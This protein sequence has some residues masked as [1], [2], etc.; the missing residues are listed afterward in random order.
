MRMHVLLAKEEETGKRAGSILE[1]TF[2]TFKHKAQEFYTAFTK[3]YKAFDA[4]D[5]D[6]VPPSSKEMVDTVPDKLKYTFKML[7]PD[8]DVLLQKE[9][10]NQIA[11]ADIIVDGVTLFTKLPVSF[12]LT[13]E[14]R[15]KKIRELLKEA[16]TL[17]N[18][19]KWIPAPNIG[20]NVY[21]SPQTTQYRSRKEPYAFV[22]KEA[23]DKFPAQVIE[24]EKTF[25]VGEY[26]ETLW[27]S[28][29]TSSTKHKWLEAIDKLIEATKIAIRTANEAEVVDRQIGTAI[30]DFILK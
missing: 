4:D 14:N 29:V 3:T 15:L 22:L 20:E 23:T 11:Q 16:P 10:T 28:R 6:L 30:L 19:V 24:K 26:T 18:G 9:A 13:L 2:A 8:I 17:P 12:L 5:K 1:E 25:T 21:V 7:A 27:D